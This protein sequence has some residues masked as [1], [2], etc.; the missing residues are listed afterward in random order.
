M[1]R[2]AERRKLSVPTQPSTCNVIPAQAGIQTT[3]FAVSEFWHKRKRPEKPSPTPLAV[4]PAAAQGRCETRPPVPSVGKGR[5]IAPA[6]GCL[7]RYT[8]RT[9][10]AIV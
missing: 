5:R 6:S 4:Q 10:M 2:M 9:I 7:L 1:P 3:R 8:L